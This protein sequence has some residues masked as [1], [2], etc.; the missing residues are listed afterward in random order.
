MGKVLFANVNGF[1]SCWNL[2]FPFNIT[3]H[4]WFLFDLLPDY[5]VFRQWH[6]K[7]LPLKGMPFPGRLSPADLDTLI[8]PDCWIRK[9][10]RTCSVIWFSYILQF[11]IEVRN[12]KLCSKANQPLPGASSETNNI[13]TGNSY[14]ANSFARDNH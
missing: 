8:Y 2:L 4:T 11:I 9:N 6:C 5:T 14:N 12:S 3:S 13:I 10:W 1:F 7:S